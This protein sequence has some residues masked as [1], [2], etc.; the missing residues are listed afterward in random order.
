[1][2]IQKKVPQINNLR[3]DLKKPAYTKINSK[4]LKD[5]NIRSDTI[6]LLE[7]NISKTFSDVSHTNV[8]LGQF[9]KAIEIKTKINNGT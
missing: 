9:P 5:L 6:K 2:P 4:W 3:L 1:M 7:E 8:F